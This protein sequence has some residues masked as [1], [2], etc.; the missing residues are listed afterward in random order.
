[1]RNKNPGP[2]ALYVTE[3]ENGDRITIV[4]SIEEYRELRLYY[5]YGS[6]ER[7]RYYSYDIVT[8]QSF[9]NLA[10]ALNGVVDYDLVIW[11]HKL[12]K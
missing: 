9:P 5:E 7:T 12:S 3:V 10:R 4:F 1:M 11:E 2:G 8:L 6:R